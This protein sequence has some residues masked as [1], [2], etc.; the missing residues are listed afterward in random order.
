MIMLIPLPKFIRK[1][2]INFYKIL[3]SRVNKYYSD[4]KIKRTV[5]WKFG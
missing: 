3:N 4:N 5:N 1:G 2:Q